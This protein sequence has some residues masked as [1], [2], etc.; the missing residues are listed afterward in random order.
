MDF[1]AM[2]RRQ[3]QELCKQHKIRANMKN[4]EMA[5][6]LTLLLHKKNEESVSDVEPAEGQLGLNEMAIDSVT[7]PKTKKVKFSPDNE[8]FYFVATDKD[9]DSDCDY[10]P[11]KKRGGRG[12]RKS[13]G[14]EGSRSGGD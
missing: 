5:Q 13:V 11:K 6:A 8:T 3:L 4:V 14:E 9:S 10:G 7:S 12:R 1:F 2:K